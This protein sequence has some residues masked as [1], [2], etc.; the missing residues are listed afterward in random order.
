[1]Q[2]AVFPEE[3]PDVLI[4]NALAVITRNL[5]GWTRPVKSNA[6]RSARSRF[7]A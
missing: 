3:K 1:M 6:W 2:A 5:E 7:R 4:M